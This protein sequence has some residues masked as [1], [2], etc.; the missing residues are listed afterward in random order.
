MYVC[1]SV[2]AGAHVYVCGDAVSMAGDV[3]EALLKVMEME[4]GRSREEAE[5]YMDQLE[6]DGRYQRD[7][8]VT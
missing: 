3:H 1:L 7:V 8:W 4:G 2:Q 5:Q 6:K